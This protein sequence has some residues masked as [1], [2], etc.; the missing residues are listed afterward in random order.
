MNNTHA[1][2]NIPGLLEY[3]EDFE[4]G[5]S[6][7]LFK[8]HS[9]L[10]KS[11][12]DEID[13]KGHIVTRFT[14]EY[15][16]SKQRQSSSLHEISYRACFKAQLPHFF[17]NLLTDPL[18]VVYDPFSGRGTTVI[19]AGLMRRNVMSND[20]NPISKILTMPRFN[21]PQTCD[22][23]SRLREIQNI[24]SKKT[25]IDLSM[26]FEESTLMEI[27]RIRVYLSKRRSEGITDHIDDWIRMISTNRLTGHSSGFF[28]VYTLPPNQA[29]SPD[30][31]KK[32]NEKRNQIPPKRDVYNLIVKKHKSLTRNVTKSQI[33]NLKEVSIN[34][35]Y[36]ACDSSET[37]SINDNSV[38]LIV[39]SPPFMNI[40][41]Y[42]KDNW[43][44]C[45]F[46]NINLSEIEPKITMAKNV[47]EWTE[48]I[49]KS[50]S[51]FYR[52][53]QF[54]KF[55]AFE[56]GEIKNKNINL[57]EIVVPIGIDAGFKCICIIIN[58]QH[59]TKTSNI[60]GVK[61]NNKGTNSNRIVIFQKS[62][63]G[64]SNVY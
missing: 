42:A 12:V 25:D 45:W 47:R 6:I 34:A 22:I 31:Q 24:K 40:V 9:S 8:D 60:W 39:T 49:R 57:D 54:G 18:D 17:I 11:S 59:F 36:Y 46:N 5:N 10:N 52:I 43:L 58:S 64:L 28:S 21:V 19:E 48:F 37:L 61:N 4:L 32:I 62:Q 41:Q 56:V 51:E 38:D 20:I 33:N 7:S 53:V 50:F 3:L 27:N 14:N 55:I 15:W 16:T 13:I 26:F 30:G 1:S 2:N 44:R 23:E 35:K 29:V 63:K